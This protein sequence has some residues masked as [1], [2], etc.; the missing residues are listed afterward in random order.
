MILL[1][2]KTGE[3]KVPLQ[4]QQHE[5]SYKLPS[6]LLHS[7]SCEKQIFSEHSRVTAMSAQ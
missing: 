3:K 7:E 4:V 5:E 1:K 2:I 6:H